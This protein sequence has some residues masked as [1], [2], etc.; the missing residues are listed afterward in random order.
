[1]QI[2]EIRMF[3]CDELRLK[4]T[5]SVTFGGVFVVK[6]VKIIDGRQGMFVAMP[7]R[8]TEGGFEDICHPVSTSY[9][10]YVEDQVLEAYARETG[11]PFAEIQARRRRSPASPPP[12]DPS[13]DHP[14]GPESR[15]S[16]E[17]RPKDPAASSDAQSS[18]TD[19]G[20]GS[21][22]DRRPLGDPEGDGGS[23]P[24]S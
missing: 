3:V 16:R 8:K 1:M 6:G 14:A 7:S 9:R 20:R 5:L 17:P 11:I 2:T 10:N 19:P 21:R 15:V 4:A 23:H 24:D 22:P 18:Q 13:D 12:A